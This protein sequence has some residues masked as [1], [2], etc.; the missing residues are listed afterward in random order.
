MIAKNSSAMSPWILRDHAEGHY[1]PHMASG[2][3]ARTED[4]ALLMDYLIRVRKAARRLPRGRRE[5]VITQVSDRLA[6]AVQAND[7]GTRDARA[8]LARFGEPR[9][10]VLAVDGHVPGTEASWMEYTAVLLV[11]AGGVLWKAAWLAGVALLWVSPRWRWPDK[12]LATLVWPGGLIVANLI[13]G[14]YSAASL[15]GPGPP[16]FFRPRVSTVHFLI[17]STLGHPPLRHLLVL[18]AA[19]VPPVL[20]AVWLLRRARR[21]ESPQTAAVAGPAVTDSAVKAPGGETGRR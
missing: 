13:A 14:R 5:W 4:D 17:N 19:A 8:T 15:L 2:S 20:V 11:L 6:H 16:P 9:D 3:G 21:P 12:L 10:V 7:G 18:L 1:C